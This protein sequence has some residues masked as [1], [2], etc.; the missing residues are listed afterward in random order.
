MFIKMICNQST[1]LILWAGRGHTIGWFV[2]SKCPYVLYTYIYVYVRKYVWCILFKFRCVISAR[3]W[4]DPKIVLC[5]AGETDEMLH[6]LYKYMHNTRWS[7]AI[8]FYL[9]PLQHIPGLGFATCKRFQR[10][11]ILKLFEC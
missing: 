6:Q 2:L 10:L 5:R 7:K 3:I 11:K 9:N 1:K 4:K 8:A